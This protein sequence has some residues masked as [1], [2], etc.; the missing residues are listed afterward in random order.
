MEFA[1]GLDPFANSAGLVPRW[2][3]AGTQLTCDFTRPAGV[4]GITYGA[5]WSP[6]LA[7]GSWL[8]LTNSSSDPAYRFSI[9]ID[10]NPRK[11]ARLTVTEP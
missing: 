9:A 5:E 3:V 6:T 11:F 1:F 8:P 10:G 4:S 7:A 2:Q